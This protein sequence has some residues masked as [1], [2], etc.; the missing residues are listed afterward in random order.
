M[1]SEREGP[2]PA[3]FPEAGDFPA[4]DV[5]KTRGFRGLD[6]GGTP[7][8]QTKIFGKPV[9]LFFHGEGV[10]RFR[11]DEGGAEFQGRFVGDHA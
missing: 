2:L 11:G 9:N 10:G 6:F 4:N 3:E 8:A 7:V 5:F 1:G